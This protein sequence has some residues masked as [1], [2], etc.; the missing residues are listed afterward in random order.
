[1]PNLYACFYKIF[2]YSLIYFAVLEIEPRVLHPRHIL[3]HLNQ[4][5]AFIIRTE[6]VLAFLHFSLSYLLPET[7]PPPVPIS[8]VH[9][10]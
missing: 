7:S 8:P 3:Y 6:F 4:A 9:P 10:P 1:M 2:I 5:P